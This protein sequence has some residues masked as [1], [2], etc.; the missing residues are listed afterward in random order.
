MKSLFIGMVGVT[1]RAGWREPM[2]EL[3]PTDWQASELAMLAGV[4]WYADPVLGSGDYP[5]EVVAVVD[6]SMVPDFNELE[7]R[8]NAGKMAS[9]GFEKVKYQWY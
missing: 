9:N 1:L 5:A 7:K 8:N 2:D 3:E 4:G 6:A